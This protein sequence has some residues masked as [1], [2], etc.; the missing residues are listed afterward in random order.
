MP[1]RVFLAE[2]SVCTF[3]IVVTFN[4]GYFAFVVPV[5]NTVCTSLHYILVTKEH[6]WLSLFEKRLTKRLGEYKARMF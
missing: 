2:C 1:N 3:N 4:D 6:H 5:Q